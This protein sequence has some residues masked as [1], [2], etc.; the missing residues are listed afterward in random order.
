MYQQRHVAARENRQRLAQVSFRDRRK[1][2]DPGGHE[3]TLEP[4][5]AGARERFEVSQIARHQAAP[6]ADIHPAA[7]RGGR[8]LCLEALNR[9]R[10][11][12]GVERH[13][14]ESRDA[15]GCGGTVSV[16]VGTGTVMRAHALEPERLQA[17]T[18][19][20]RRSCGMTT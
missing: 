4:E 14:N 12:H 20:C 3:K 8:T 16:T 13:V 18:E 15:T 10:R 7:T 2:V 19:G 9:G 17:R 5:N 1:L 11:R 6:E